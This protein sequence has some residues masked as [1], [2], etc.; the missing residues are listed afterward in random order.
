MPAIDLT[1]E[2]FTLYGSRLGTLHLVGENIDNGSRWTIKQLDI[3]NPHATMIAKGSWLLKGPERGVSLDGEIKFINLGKL[4][5]QMGYENRAAEGEGTIKAKINWLNFPWVFSY[6]GLN[7]EANIDLKNGVFQHVNSRSARLLE[8]LSLQSLQ[9]ILSLNFRTGEE[10]KDGFPWN[11]IAGDFTLNQGVVNTK[12]LVV[13][14]PIAR[15]SL[16]GGS[17]LNRKVWDLN[18]DVR[19][20]LDMS[21]AAVATAF[22]VNPI[23]GLSALVS[24]FLL[25]NPIERAM[26][27][28]YQV[29]GTWDEPELIPVGV[30][31]PVPDQ[32]VIGG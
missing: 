8:V 30:P 9:R 15:I 28:K 1:V 13:R 5:D 14:S 24:Q 7:G 32:P 17:D 22:V 3:T 12:D 11:S 27:A 20:I 25:R 23:A 19:P 6:A 21:G 26:S 29:K 4:S 10:F 16:T 2:D 31:T 18:A